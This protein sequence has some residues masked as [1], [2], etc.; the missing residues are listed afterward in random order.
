MIDVRETR[1]ELRFERVVAAEQKAELRGL[2]R[3]AFLIRQTAIELIEQH[4]GVPSPVGHPVHTRA[5]AAKVAMAY[6]RNKDQRV[7]LIG[8]RYSVLGVSLSAHEFGKFF[9]GYPYP[10]RPTM[11]PALKKNIGKIPGGFAATVTTS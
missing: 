2:A 6:D 9:R 1:L 4:G 5:G 7:A 11:G 8:P 10:K 3:A